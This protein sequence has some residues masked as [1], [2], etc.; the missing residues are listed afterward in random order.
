M[1]RITNCI[2]NSW[3][4]VLVELY[5]E[6]LATLNTQILPTISYQPKPENIFRVLSMPIESIKVVIIGQDPYP[7]P[8]DAVGYAFAKPPLVS[9]PVSLRNIEKEVRESGQ[10]NKSN[11]IDLFAWVDQGVFLLNTALTVET[12]KPGSHLKY[13]ENFTKRLISYISINQPCIWVLWGAKAQKFI[14][15]ISNKFVVSDNYD[16][17]CIKSIP[18]NNRYN[19]ILTAP[20]PAAEAYSGGK[21]GFFGCDHFYKINEI[22]NKNGIQPIIW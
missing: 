12:G 2:H 20:H 21:A 1:S 16:R 19:Y 18:F 14:P 9:K 6:P 8:G 3:K 4:P 11:E 17:E 7:T 22:L 5:K 10:I 15:N 13:W